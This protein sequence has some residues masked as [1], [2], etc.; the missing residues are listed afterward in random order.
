MDTAIRHRPRPLRLRRRDH[1]AAPEQAGDAVAATREPSFLLAKPEK[2]GRQPSARRRPR[3]VN[4]DDMTAC[5]ADPPNANGPA[6]RDLSIMS[7]SCPLASTS[8]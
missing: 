5:G 7:A 2:R 8:R 6:T 3:G 4:P 1:A